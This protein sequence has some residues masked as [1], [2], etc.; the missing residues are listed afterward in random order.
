L[1]E[2]TGKQPSD[3]NGVVMIDYKDMKEQDIRWLRNNMGY[4]GQEPV[5][6]NDTIYN[7][8]AY[9]KDNCTREEVEKAAKN[10][11]AHDFICSLEEGYD[12]MVGIGGGKIR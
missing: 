4:V 5:L 10:A 9:G 12:T 11:N 8:I 3:K 6:F 2:E 7:N 1:D